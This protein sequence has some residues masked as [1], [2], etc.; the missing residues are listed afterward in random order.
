MGAR[1]QRILAAQPKEG[2]PEEQID[3]AVDAL[4]KELE[5]EMNKPPQPAGKT[6]DPEKH[7]DIFVSFRQSADYLRQLNAKLRKLAE[8]KGLTQE[9]N[10]MRRL[11]TNWMGFLEQSTGK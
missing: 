1:F 2:T 9:E 10:A 6:D 3:R 4:V 7:G 11:L 5:Q 8:R